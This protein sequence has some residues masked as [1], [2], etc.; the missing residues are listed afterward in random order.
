MTILD[1]ILEQKRLELPALQA[2][3][4][5]FQTVLKTRPSL[6]ENLIKS[7]TLQVIA[8]MK[9]A[10][11]SKGDIATH[12][13]PIDQALQ[14]E[15]A[16]AACI[17]VLTEHAYF[18]GSFQDLNAVANAVAIPVLCKD[19]IIDSVQIDYAK[20]AGASVILLI[21]AALK[22]EQLQSLY[23]YAAAKNLEVLVEVHDIDELQ[24]ATAIGAKIIG[25]N[26]RNL[27]TFEVTLSKTAEIAQHL[28]SSTTA[29]ISESG[30]WNAEDARFVANAGAKAV[31]VGESL[32][33]S[34]DVKTSLQNLQIDITTKAGEK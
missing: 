5:N 20:A 11:P 13:D 16:G 24:C 28:P 12:I 30:I 23:T 2:A 25:V 3:K 26:N 21:V 34:G 9:R 1:K 14:Y 18:K 29:F 32:M 10:S 6:Y 31:L 33:R 15:Q 8:E 7:D 19:F 4:P 17:S 27:K 22:N